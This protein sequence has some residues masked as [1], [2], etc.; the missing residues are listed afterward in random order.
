MKYTVL[1][2]ALLLHFSSYAQPKECSTLWMGDTYDSVDVFKKTAE[3]YLQTSLKL[4]PNEGVKTMYEMQDEGGI[5]SLRVWMKQKKVVAGGSV[6][7]I[8][9]IS[10]FKITGVTENIEA[11]F[12]ALQSKVK[13]CILQNSGSGTT[14]SYGKMT[15]EKQGGDWS[16]KNISLS[17][18]TLTST[19]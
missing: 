15:V 6:S 10:S 13:D 17:T 11:L 12:A 7:T 14:F 19:K 3:Q 8:Y 9:V 18:L 4:L 16:K 5:S 1:I 2:W